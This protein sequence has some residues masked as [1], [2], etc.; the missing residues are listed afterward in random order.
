MADIIADAAPIEEPVVETPEPEDKP[1]EQEPVAEIA[2]EQKP[3][4]E[5]PQVRKSAKDYIIERKDAK[6]AKL[7]GQENAPQDQAQAQPLTRDDLNSA[8]EPLK[9]SLVQSEDEKELQAAI[10]KYPDAKKIE[11]NVRKY[12]ENEAYAAVPVEFI[13]RGLLG[14]REAAKA[15]ADT[16][17][18][19]SRQGGHS[20]RPAEIKE[21]SAWD[22]TDAEFDKQVSKLMS[23]QQ[24]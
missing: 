9:R 1:E 11:K 23:G 20:K 5:E 14:A 21:K 10:A 2:P 4:D 12:M 16:E 19:G 8:L 18:K 15:Q 24:Q 7:T 17:A 13:V 22:L 6:I 3:E